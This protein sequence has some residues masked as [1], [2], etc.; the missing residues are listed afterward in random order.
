MAYQKQNW[1]DLPDRSTPITA[2]KMLHIEDGIEEA[3]N[4]GGGGET[5]PVGSE[6]DF[7]GSTIPTG[8]EEVTNPETYSTDEVKTDKIY[9]DE[10][11][12]SH[13]VYRKR[14][15]GTKRSSNLTLGTLPNDADIIVEY[16]GTFIDSNDNKKPIPY[17]FSS[18]I[19]ISY[20]INSGG[21]I[22]VYG[23]SSAYS[24]GTVSVTLEY[25]KNEGGN[26]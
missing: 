9:V 1:I 15:V 19:W 14:F 26:S 3:Y 6:I 24:E 25:T 10:N 4:H 21:E 13:E 8:W 23:A 17:Y 20:E 2:S 5:L 18:N 11:D 22:I 16:K 7:E 12:V